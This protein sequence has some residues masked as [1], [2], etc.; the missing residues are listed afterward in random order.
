M[1]TRSKKVL[2]EVTKALDTPKKPSAKKKTNVKRVKPAGAAT[3]SQEP[4]V[5]TGPELVDRKLAAQYAPPVQQIFD[6]G[7]DRMRSEF[8]KATKKGENV[9]PGFQTVF[10]DTCQFQTAVATDM[11]GNPIQVSPENMLPNGDK[12]HIAGQVPDQAAA[13][14]CPNTA[15]P[16]RIF[17]LAMNGLSGMGEFTITQNDDRTVLRLIIGAHL[18][19]E[20]AMPDG[21]LAIK[22]DFVSAGH[23]CKF[24]GTYTDKSGGAVRLLRDSMT[25]QM[26]RI[27]SA[28]E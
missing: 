8:E 21:I 6:K 18:T 5:R 15:L 19:V 11:N 1:A 2:T 25:E 26:H 12:F 23:N 14:G 22:A 28:H 16:A 4:P 17:A 9:Q 27:Y 3:A 13:D 7:A 20:Y 10:Q 24:T